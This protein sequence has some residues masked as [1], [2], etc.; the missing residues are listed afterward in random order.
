MEEKTVEQQ[1]NEMRAVQGTLRWEM[2]LLADQ[3]DILLGLLK[4]RGEL[5]PELAD[6]VRREMA[7]EQAILPPG[8]WPI[9]LEEKDAEDWQRS[10]VL[11]ITRRLK[12]ALA[13][14]DQKERLQRAKERAADRRWAKLL[15]GVWDRAAMANG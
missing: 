4:G 7:A 5:P 8:D 10:W 1:L 2:G 3:R 6:E 9:T 11:D 12:E 15:D 13:R 14:S